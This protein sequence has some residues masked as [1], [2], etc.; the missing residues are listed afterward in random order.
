MSPPQADRSVLRTAAE[1]DGHM[2]DV[3]RT[4]GAATS[5]V[6]VAVPDGDRAAAIARALAAEHLMPV[7]AFSRDALLGFAAD[8]HVAAVVIDIDLEPGV[9]CGDRPALLPAVRAVTAAPIVVLGFVPGVGPD[10][11]GTGADDLLGRD[12]SPADVVGSVLTALARGVPA[13]EVMACA[14]LVVDLRNYE[15]WRGSQRLALTPTE[16]RVLGALVGA[17]GDVVTK[18]DLQRAAWGTAGAHD[19]N[20]LQAHM[21]RL[22]SKLDGAVGDPGCRVRTVRGV[23]FRLERDLGAGALV[24][25]A[26][27]IGANQSALGIATVVSG[28]AGVSNSTVVTLDRAFDD[29]GGASASADAS[30]SGAE[31][32]ANAQVGN[33]QTAGVT[34]SNNGSASS[35][36]DQATTANGQAAIIGQGASAGASAQVNGNGGGLHTDTTSATPDGRRPA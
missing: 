26:T 2:A 35:G 9:A 21:R 14:D 27:G 24:H 32:D 33:V 3:E 28:T 12:A 7:V 25:E 18:H 23:G 20:R 22:R 16:I 31:S 4:H 6:L 30:G 1:A 19:D 5:I 11:L 10:A 15:A 17:Q 13:D 29:N 8:G 36:D 34:V